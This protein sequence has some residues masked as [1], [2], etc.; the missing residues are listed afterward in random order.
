MCDDLTVADEAA[1]DRRSFAMMAGAAT[2]AGM[3]AP[4]SAA[5]ASLTEREVTLTTADGTVDAYFVHPAKGKHAAVILWPDIRGLRAAFRTMAKRL[6]ADGYAVLVPNPF[7]RSAPAPVI[8]EG[9]NFADPA[10]RAKLTPMAQKL[11]ADANAI[12]TTAFVAWLDKQMPVNTR[13][14]VGTMGYCMGGAIVLRGAAAVPARVGAGAS[15][16]GG[17]LA[18]DKPDS[19]HL[20]APKMKAVFLVAVAENDDKRDPGEKDRLRAAL[21]A[22]KVPAEIEVYSGAMHGWCVIDSPSFNGP[23]AEKAWSRMLALFKT[24]LA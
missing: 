22:A 4:A 2:A 5:T 7:Y 16:H 21:D 15:F 3:I 23:Q 11:T 6:A 8:P 13:R 18:T 10:I 1:F 17:N 20:F 9:S 12:D 19:P 14:K 24:R